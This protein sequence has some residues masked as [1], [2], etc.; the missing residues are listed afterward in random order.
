MF[1]TTYLAIQIAKPQISNVPATEV[2]ATVIG[3]NK[4]ESKIDPDSSGD[5]SML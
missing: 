3:E 4:L 2:P 5:V 1:S